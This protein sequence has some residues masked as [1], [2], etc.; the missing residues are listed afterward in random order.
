MRIIVLL[1]LLL[2]PVQQACAEFKTGQYLKA[3]ETA[4]GIERTEL[5]LIIGSAGAAYGWANGTLLERGDKALY[6]QP[7]KMALTNSQLHEILQTYTDA[8]QFA[9][10]YE[11]SLVL[12]K[13]L[14]DTFPCTK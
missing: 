9:K 8:N 10:T 1:A 14:I 6:C 2:L 12:L 3:W 7:P 5:E 13:A 11:M 4:Q